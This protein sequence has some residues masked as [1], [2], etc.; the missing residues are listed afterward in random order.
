MSHE[1]PPRSL[2]ASALRCFMS[3]VKT[4]NVPNALV[5]RGMVRYTHT[6]HVL[7]RAEDA[8]PAGYDLHQRMNHSLFTPQTRQFY[9]DS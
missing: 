8:G 2:L 4:R 5:D 9:R 3:V 1:H 6:V 7:N